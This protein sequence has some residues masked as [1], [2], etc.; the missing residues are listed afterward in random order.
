MADEKAK[1]KLEREYLHT[2]Q[3]GASQ[4]KARKPAAR[5]DAEARIW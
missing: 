2:P 1:P 3:G 5:E 4:L